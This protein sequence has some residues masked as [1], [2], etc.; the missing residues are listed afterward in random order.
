MQ[1]GERTV[2]GE[3]VAACVRTGLFS[4][5]REARFL[6][7]GRTDRGVHARGQVFS[8]STPYPDRA[9]AALN[10]QLPP[11]LWVTGAAI[12][13][14]G[15]H[16][17]YQARCRTYRYYFTEPYLD[18]GVMDH[19][20]RAFEGVHDFSAFARVEGGKDPVREVFSARVFHESDLPV[21]EVRAESFLWHMVRYM[22]AALFTVGQGSAGSRSVSD[23]L[24]GLTGPALS[25][26]PPAGLIL[27]DV[28]VGVTFSAIPLDDRTSRFLDGQWQ[29]HRLMQRVCEAV[30]EDRPRG[31]GE[32]NHEAW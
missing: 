9:V 19:A 11:D 21:L 18:S 10:W 24:A 15:F 3:F 31:T 16:P 28:D 29:H 4:H 5:H 8:F 2:E 20:A 14:D 26:A 30:R 32:W 25:P 17:R 13:G 22:A 1:P 27:W 23:R 6:A 12:V 7:A